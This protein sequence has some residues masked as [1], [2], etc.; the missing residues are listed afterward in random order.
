MNVLERE[1]VEISKTTFWR[2]YVSTIMDAKKKFVTKLQKERIGEPCVRGD[3]WQENLKLLD[4]V[5]GLPSKM[6]NLV[7]GKE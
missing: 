2:D 4:E 6:L 7:A 1:W 3:I 5:L